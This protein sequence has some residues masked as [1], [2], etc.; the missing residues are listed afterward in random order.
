MTLDL[1]DIVEN[2]LTS[3]YCSFW[4]HSSSQIKRVDETRRNCSKIPLCALLLLTV[5]SRKQH[6]DTLLYHPDSHSKLLR[7]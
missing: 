1:H 6:C 2:A 4:I 7:A 5:P 3:S